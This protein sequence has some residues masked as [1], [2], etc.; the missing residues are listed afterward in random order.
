MIQRLGSL[1]GNRA[2]TAQLEKDPDG[3][4]PA[5]LR[6]GI[7]RLSGVAMDDV[8]VHYGSSEPARYDALA[9]AR[10]STI[11][12]APGQE[13]HL[14][15]EA[16][17]TVQQKQGRVAPSIEVAGAPVNDDPSLEREAD[18]MGRRALGS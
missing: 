11:H 3:G 12:L 8:R 5:P 15:H 4:L 18:V 2:V 6:A 7:E 9:F 10:G 17:H 1:A 14:P 13:R 16:W